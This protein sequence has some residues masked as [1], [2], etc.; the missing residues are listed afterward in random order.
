MRLADTAIRLK[1]ERI[2]ALER[3]LERIR[4]TM[5]T[6]LDMRFD[7]ID[8][9]F[10]RAIR[11]VAFIGRYDLDPSKVE[12]VT[13]EP[14]PWDNAPN[15][16]CDWRFSISYRANAVYGISGFVTNYYSE[17]ALVDAWEMVANDELK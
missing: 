12:L 5:A 13:F 1:Q 2:A 9:D 4:G 10:V 11:T 3:Q 14:R 16:S 8:Q 7:S 6:N 15:A 17:R